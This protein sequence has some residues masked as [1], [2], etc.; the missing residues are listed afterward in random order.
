MRLVVDRELCVGAGQCALST[1]E[2]FD[3][4]DDGRVVLRRTLPEDELAAKSRT[5]VELC[6]SG[7]LTLTDD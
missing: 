4:G 7:A 3:Q 1:P 2:L 5:A 6:P